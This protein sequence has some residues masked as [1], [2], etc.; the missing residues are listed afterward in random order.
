MAYHQAGHAVIARILGMTCGGATIVADCNSAY[1]LTDV[2]RSITD[3]WCRGRSRYNSMFRARI[4]TLMA[5]RESENACVGQD[6]DTPFAADADLLE[7]ERTAPEAEVSSAQIIKLQ[8]RTRG[9]VRRHQQSIE[10]VAA[11]LLQRGALEARQI[12]ELVIASGVRLAERVD[13]RA[14][15]VEEKYA[16]HQ[17]WTHGRRP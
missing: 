8:A 9:L 4:M 16:R 13:P 11:A 7:I 1:S 6:E 17:A 14:V 5:G 12:D 10:L 3:W 15:S 2:D